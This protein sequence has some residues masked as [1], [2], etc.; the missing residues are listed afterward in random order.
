M[1]GPRIASLCEACLR[2]RGA[3]EQRGRTE[4]R[5]RVPEVTR[6]CRLEEKSVSRLLQLVL[7]HPLAGMLRQRLPRP[8][9]HELDQIREAMYQTI[10]DGS[11]DIGV[12]IIF[13]SEERWVRRSVGERHQTKD[14]RS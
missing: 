14:S 12:D 8:L 1:A 7:D 2:R 9:K 5:L 10:T 11:P 6:G 13:T 3:T 4:G